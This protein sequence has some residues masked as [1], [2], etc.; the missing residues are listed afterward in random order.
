M[1]NF[2][3]IPAT[4]FYHTMEPEL[5]FLSLRLWHGLYHAMH[6]AYLQSGGPPPD[7]IYEFKIEALRTTV[8]PPGERDNRQIQKAMDGLRESLLVDGICFGKNGRSL[9][10]QLGQTVYDIIDKHPKPYARMDI[11]L[12]SKCRSKPDILW[13]QNTLSH[14][15]MDFPKYLLSPMHFLTRCQRVSELRAAQRISLVTGYRFAVGITQCYFTDAITD[16]TV[17]IA[18]QKTKWHERNFFAFN[19]HTT[20]HV[21]DAGVAS[22]RS[23]AAARD[24]KNWRKPAPQLAG[25]DGEM[26]GQP[27]QCPSSRSDEGCDHDCQ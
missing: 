7:G 15:R 23:K 11:S 6:Q 21:F 26:N 8:L 10:F 16:V 3:N 12:V 14:S 24:R 20:I 27:S 22:V 2:Y 4:L 19:P 17:K 9:R 1:F 25:S 5:S 13:L 18:H